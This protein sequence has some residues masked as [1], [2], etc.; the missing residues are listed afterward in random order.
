MFKVEIT[1]FRQLGLSAILV[2]CLIEG[3]GN[4]RSSRRADC[5][6]CAQSGENA[7]GK[8]EKLSPSQRELYIGFSLGDQTIKLEKDNASVLCFLGKYFR[9]VEMTVN[10][11]KLCQNFFGCTKTMGLK[12]E[13]IKEFAKMLRRHRSFC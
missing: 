5:R 12:I 10:M 1:A 8:G 13:P 9:S 11:G 3:D 4:I 6:R 7:P 2:T